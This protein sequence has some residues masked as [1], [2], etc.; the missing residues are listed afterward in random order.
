MSNFVPR[1]L[2]LFVGFILPNLS[3]AVLCRRASF[4]EM[5]RGT[6]SRLCWL[7]RGRTGHSFCAIHWARALPPPAVRPQYLQ[8]VGRRLITRSDRGE[9]NFL[10]L[11]VIPSAN[12]A[13]HSMR[14]GLFPLARR[15]FVPPQAGVGP[16][17][18]SRQRLLLRRRGLPESHAKLHAGE[19]RGR[20]QHRML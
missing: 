19:P 20:V 10:M 8:P 13:H 7:T 9:P 3:R 2:S 6:W 1:S 15:C 4:L 16:E 18:H 11:A 14:L 17:S 12:A 5:T